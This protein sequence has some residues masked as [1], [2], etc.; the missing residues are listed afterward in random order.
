MLISAR[1]SEK[2]RD[3]RRQTQTRRS[4]TDLAG[5]FITLVPGRVSSSNINSRGRTGD[6]KTLKHQN[7]AICDTHVL[8]ISP[9]ARQKCRIRIRHVLIHVAITQTG[10]TASPSRPPPK[11]RASYHLGGL[12]VSTFFFYHCS[13]FS[14]V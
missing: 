8:S 12:F 7:T 14:W 2:T 9:G 6:S 5:E 13:I 3:K 11:A 4:I 1:I 10:F